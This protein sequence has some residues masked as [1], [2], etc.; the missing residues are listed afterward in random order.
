MIKKTHKLLFLMIG[1]L[2]LSGQNVFAFKDIEGDPAQAKI[3]ALQKANIISGL[4]NDTFDPK[5]SVT[6]A[7]GIQ[8]IVNGLDLNLD[9][10]RFIK[11]PKA[12]DSFDNVPNNAWY[13]PAMITA[14]HNGIPLTRDIEPTSLLTRE[15]FAA[16]LA[17]A[18][19]NKVNYETTQMGLIIKDE[20]DFTPANL[21]AVQDLLLIKAT[22]LHDGNFSPKN[23]IIRSE[24]AEIL[25]NTVMFAKVQP[26]GNFH[27][28]LEPIEALKE[29]I[30]VQIIP[31]SQDLNKV[32]LS[33]GI[34]PNSGY[35]IKIKGIDLTKDNQAIIRY[36]LQNPEPGHFYAQVMTEPQVTTY[37][38]ANY[39]V[40]AKQE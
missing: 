3:D 7:Q 34:K 10:I 29:E 36:S 25:Y 15:T 13:A 28:Q 19:R 22:S 30:S 39:T 33:R 4:N 5:G 35:S 32:T 27:S 1:M 12:S 23:E 17:S 11:E 20:K 37:I 38:A 24:A 26:S 14:I 16:Y 6:V 40:T 21:S 2:I 18:L 31:V 9:H 8:M